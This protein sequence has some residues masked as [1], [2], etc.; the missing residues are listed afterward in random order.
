MSKIALEKVFC[1]SKRTDKDLI[2]DILTCIERIENY[3]LDSN[4]ENFTNDFKTQD[5]VIRNIEIIGEATKKLTIEIRENNPH[6]P[7]KNITGTRDKLIHD[8]LGVNIDIVWAIVTEELPNLKK[9]L[10]EIIL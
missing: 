1:M 5:A 10:K 2:Q 9:E 6:I 8:Y 7:W 3:T 4:Y